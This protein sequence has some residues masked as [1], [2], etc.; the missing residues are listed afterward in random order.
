MNVDWGQRIGLVILACTAVPACQEPGGA[1]EQVVSL[2]L[3]QS[4]DTALSES[5]IDIGE[6]RDTDCAA[7]IDQRPPASSEKL[8]CR[9]DDRGELS[10]AWLQDYSM[11]GDPDCNPATSPCGPQPRVLDCGELGQCNLGG[12]QLELRSDHS[13]WILASITAPNYEPTMSGLWLAHYSADGEELSAE[14]IAGELVGEDEYVGYS[15]GFAVDHRDHAFVVIGKDKGEAGAYPW[16]PPSQDDAEHTSWMVE[17]DADGNQVGPRI[18]IVGGAERPWFSTARPISAGRDALAL[19][20]PQ[21]VSGSIAM[22]SADG[23]V[24]WV[25]TREGRL[26]AS[27]AASDP[28]GRVSL[29]TTSPDQSPS[30]RIEHYSEDGELAWER[31]LPWR[32]DSNRFGGSPEI[33]I[34]SEGDLLTSSTL[35]NEY[36]ETVVQKLTEKGESQWITGIVATPLETQSGSGW[37]GTFGGGKVLVGTDG[38]LFISGGSYQLYAENGE[39]TPPTSLLYELSADGQDCGFWHWESEALDPQTV[40]SVDGETFFF[41]SW[42]GFGRVER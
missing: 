12:F 9:P 35:W 10:V 16:S 29:M 30:G 8:T 27:G 23:E 38:T 33:T 24:R 39:S 28:R 40:V 32:E 5:A 3:L 22:L 31:T 2:L 18:P 17:F 7:P 37:S 25:Q 36:Q 20:E 15:G 41:A 19:V 13:L 4:E 34:V 6:C 26:G 21:L 1:N 42:N 11:P 14:I